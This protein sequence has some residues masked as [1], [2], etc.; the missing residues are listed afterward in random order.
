VIRVVALC[1]A[2]ALLG[3]ASTTV[4]QVGRTRAAI[5]LPAAAPVA[6]VI[7]LPGGNTLL[8]IDAGGDSASTNF[9]IAVR[10]EFVDAGFAI[11]YVEDPSDLRPLIS[12]MR[13]VARPVFLLGTSNGTAVAA[14]SAASLGADGPDGIVLTS[15]V[16]RSGRE[17]GYS[18][19][20]ADF[21]RIT[22]PVLF[23]HNRNDTCIASPPGG[24][25]GLIA[26]LPK[27][28]DV[29]R[30]DVAS[31]RTTDDPCGP[32]APHGYLGIRDEVVA[33]IVAWMRAHAAQG[34][35]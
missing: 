21:G 8:R 29:T 10:Q 5:V 6:S 24:I 7:L 35:G 16:T 31:E 28:A 33:Q 26:H 12:R 3:A 15:T 22:V 11:A 20:D 2:V 27:G 25:A 9:L 34:A 30:I 4:E 23:V 13:R 32:F 17:Y 19:A 18:A 1:A 14:R